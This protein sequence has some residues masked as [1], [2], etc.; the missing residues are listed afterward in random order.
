MVLFLNIT[1][2]LTGCKKS[3]C[4]NISLLYVACELRFLPIEAKTSS[5]VL[6]LDLCPDVCRRAS[7]W[8]S[9]VSLCL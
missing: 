4:L 5:S 2:V 3:I 8:A 6:Y 7:E 9:V 1:I